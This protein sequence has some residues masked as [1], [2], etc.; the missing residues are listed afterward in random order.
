MI[1]ASTLKVV[2]TIEGFKQPRQAIVF[3]RDG[4]F[5]YVL[6]EDLSIAKVERGAQRVVST[7]AV[8]AATP[9]QQ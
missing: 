6:N 9:A 3:T 2:A 7:L 1:D 5:A 4:Q 8:V